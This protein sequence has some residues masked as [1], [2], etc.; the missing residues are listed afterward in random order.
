MLSLISGCFYFY[1]QNVQSISMQTSTSYKTKIN[2]TDKNKQTTPDQN[3][4][5]K[6]ELSVKTKKE[7]LEPDN[8]KKSSTKKE[9]PSSY[10]DFLKRKKMKIEL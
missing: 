5:E 9:I 10:K 4:V 6:Y 3:N 8:K 1:S 2:S 7:S